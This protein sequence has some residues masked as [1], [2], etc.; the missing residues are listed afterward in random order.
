MTSYNSLTEDILCFEVSYL[1]VMFALNNFLSCFV[2]F[3]I[4]PRVQK[5]NQNP[6]IMDISTTLFSLDYP[7]IAVILGAPDF[8]GFVLFS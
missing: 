5:R 4:C 2:K 1:R 6:K 8:K 3:I 7:E